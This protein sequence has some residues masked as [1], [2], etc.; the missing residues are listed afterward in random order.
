[1]AT[2]NGNVLTLLDHAKR[3][4]PN[5]SAATIV[6]LLMQTNEML[7]DMVYVEGNLPTG[8]RITQ[9]TGLPQV[10]WRTINQGVPPSKSRTAQVDEHAG[11]L[12]AWSEVDVELY[13]LN[14][15]RDSFRLSEGKAFIEAMNQEMQSTMLY[16]NA[17][18]SPEEFTGIA[19]RFSDTTAGNGDNII[20]A[21]GMGMDLT[22]IYLIAWG[23]ETVHGI[24]PQ[25]STA[26]LQ[27]ND[28]GEVTVEVTNGI[29]GSRMRALQEM[30]QWKSGIAVRD[31]RYIVRIANIDISDLGGMTPADLITLMEEA[32]MRL[33]NRLGRPVFYMNRT[34]QRYLR[35]QVREQVGAGGGL[36]FDNYMG[37]RVLMFGD[38]PVRMVDAILNTEDAAV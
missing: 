32:V 21:Q 7:D 8:T 22:S 34:V 31:W 38:V 27:H 17:G 13:K 16:G 23:E 10:Y 29:G 37:K 33:P 25:G 2:L 36:T 3:S 6:E 12:E 28:Y 18:L 15:Q 35:K 26:G 1:M 4:D 5:G 20:D 9:R 14:G 19:P 30:W 24:Y 11:M